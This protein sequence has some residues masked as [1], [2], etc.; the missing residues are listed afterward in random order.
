MCMLLYTVCINHSTSKNSS[1]HVVECHRL[2]FT[3]PV[4]FGTDIKNSWSILSGVRGS[5]VKDPIQGATVMEPVIPEGHSE[6]QTQQFSSHK[7][8]R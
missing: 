7:P 4:S 1:G 8:C 3:L 2:S 6:Y 5:K